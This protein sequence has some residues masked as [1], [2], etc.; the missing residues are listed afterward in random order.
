[1]HKEFQNKKAELE[2]LMQKQADGVFICSR[3]VYIEDSEKCST[4]F[5]QLEKCNYKTNSIRSI[6]TDS[7]TIS[8]PEDILDEQYQYYKSNNKEWDGLC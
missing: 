1:M 5:L 6:K 4:Y 2:N 8:K 3:A 7:G